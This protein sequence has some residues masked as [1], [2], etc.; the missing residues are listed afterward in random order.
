MML[1][2][3]VQTAVA[4]PPQDGA[5]AEEIVVIGEKLK[6]WRAEIRFTK[7]GANCKIKVS[8]GDAAIDRIG[9]A[10]MEQCW[11]DFLP[12]FEATRA[13]GVA[14][15][16]RKARTAALNTELGACVMDRREALI[17]ELADARVAGRIGE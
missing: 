15:A 11:P 5:V 13:K 3:T 2:H 1:A 4:P 8:T 9:C 12:R 16:D 6:A 10:A 17:A 7:T 14:A